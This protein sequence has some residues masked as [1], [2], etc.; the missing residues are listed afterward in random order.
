MNRP[1]LL[2]RTDPGDTGPARVPAPLRLVQPDPSI[3]ARIDHAAITHNLRVLRR[4]ARTPLLAVVKADGFGHGAIAVARTA[5]AAGAE[6]LG[7]ATADEA[8]DLR[9]GGITAPILAWLVD[10]WVDLDAAV[11]AGITLSCP[12]VPTLESVLAAARRTGTP[13]E[14][15]LEVDTGMAR[16]GSARED[17]PELC[18]RAAQV[19]FLGPVTVTGVWSHLGAASTPGWSAVARPHRAF[20]AAVELARSEGL[21]PSVLHLANTAATLAHPQTAFDLARCGAGVYGI[22]TVNGR[23]HGLRPALRLTTRVTQLRRVGAGVGVS[24]D[25]AY[26]TPRATTLALLPAGYADGVPR[27]LSAGG[28]V[29]LGGTRRPVVG[30]VSMDQLV[31]DVGDAPVQLGGEAVLLGDP[32]AGEPGVGEWAALADV[33]PHE[34]LTGIGPRVVRRHVGVPA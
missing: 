7:V 28:T 5:L 8:L 12:N 17:W 26:V 24:Y 1:E 22:D 29:T 13:A 25:H 3:V 6:W 33:L 30:A 10:P 31:V 15:H 27:A 11:A 21:S 19:Q 14:V 32:A 16:G 18:R 34:I 20:V 9:R 2:G 23:P 4:H